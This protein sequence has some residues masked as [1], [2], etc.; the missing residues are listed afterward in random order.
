MIDFSYIIS[1]LR[2]LYELIHNL[3]HAS[4]F[5]LSFCHTFFRLGATLMSFQKIFMFYINV[6][7]VSSNMQY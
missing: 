5:F 3:L 2:I 7:Q 6:I 4:G 1:R